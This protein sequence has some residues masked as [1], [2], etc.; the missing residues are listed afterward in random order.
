MTRQEFIDRINDFDGLLYFCNNES[1]ENDLDWYYNI[2]GYYEM[3][4]KVEEDI[5]EALNSNYWCYIRDMLNVIPDRGDYFERVG[6]LAYNCID[7][8]FDQFK[9]DVLRYA[10]ARGLWEEDET[11]TKTVVFADTPI[12]PALVI[13]EPFT[14]EELLFSTS[15]KG[16]V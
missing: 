6:I 9:N 7:N 8:D 15:I 13:D 5:T 4:E 2:Y 10:D 12:E 16:V 11:E 1:L 14:V 3:R